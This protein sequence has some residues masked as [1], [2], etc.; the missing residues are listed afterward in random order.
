V[1][2]IERYR[3]V[4][5]RVPVCLPVD[6]R[7]VETHAAS[8]HAFGKH[9]R[10]H[11]Q[12]AGLIRP[13]L[14]DARRHVALEQPFSLCSDGGRACLHHWRCDFR[15]AADTCTRTAGASVSGHVVCKHMQSR[16]SMV[17]PAA[18]PSCCKS[19][20]SLSSNS[21]P[22][23]P[24]PRAAAAGLRST[25]LAAF[26]IACACAALGW[27]DGAPGAGMQVRASGASPPLSS[28][29]LPLTLVKR[30]ARNGAS[31]SAARGQLRATNPRPEPASCCRQGG[32]ASTQSPARGG[33]GARRRGATQ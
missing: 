22:S 15:Y 29:S 32:P 26:A 5:R 31:L 10:T 27:M 25:V 14:V 2:V 18:A 16:A 20:T 6:R 19:V 24:P 33:A 1:C 3:G 4:C 30:S 17:G 23:P 7:H 11:Q 12:N 28:L 9:A 13:P 8:T 21:A